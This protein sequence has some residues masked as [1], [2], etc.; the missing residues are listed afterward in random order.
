LIWQTFSHCYLAT[1]KNLLTGLP[2]SIGCLSRLIRLDVHQNSEFFK[3]WSTFSFFFFFGFSI[4]HSDLE[5]MCQ[6][7][8]EYRQSLHQSMVV[9]H[10][11]SF[12]WGQIL[13]YSDASLHIIK[14]ILC[15]VFLSAWTICISHTFCVYFFPLNLG[16]TI[17]LPYQWR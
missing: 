13:T 14:S 4:I 17:F 10:L 11:Q 8:K 16:I 6:S 12:I 5:I 9:I 7:V 15:V 2:V 3:Q 1:A